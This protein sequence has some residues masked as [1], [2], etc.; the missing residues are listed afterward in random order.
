MLIRNFK[1][2]LLDVRVYD[3]R[4]NMGKAAADDVAACIKKLLSVKDDIYMIFAA[5]PSQNE[6]LSALA[7]NDGIEYRIQ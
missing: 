5:A 7:D 3:T 6:F 4:L 2:D 1:A